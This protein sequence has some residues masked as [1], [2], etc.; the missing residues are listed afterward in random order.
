MPNALRTNNVSTDPTVQLQQLKAA[1]QQCR[2]HRL[3]NIILFKWNQSQQWRH[4]CR[5]VFVNK[6]LSP[7]TPFFDSQW[8]KEAR[9]S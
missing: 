9:L 2:T 8:I 1:I 4:T 7:P 6:P 5:R 3:F